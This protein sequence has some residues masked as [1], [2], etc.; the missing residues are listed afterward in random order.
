MCDDVANCTEEE[1]EHSKKQKSVPTTANYG[2]A[3]VLKKK[4]AK[5]KEK[6]MLD[7]CQ[8]CKGERSRLEKHKQHSPRKDCCLTKMLTNEADFRGQKNM[9]EEVLFSLGCSFVFPL[10]CCSFLFSDHRGCRSDLSFLAEV[11]LR[12]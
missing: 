3:R 1:V 9:V 12:A 5:S 4:S 6:E 8:Q 10:T 2:E 7:M 11:S